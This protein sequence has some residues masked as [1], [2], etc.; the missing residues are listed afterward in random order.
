[1]G[2]SSSNPKLPVDFRNLGWYGQGNTTNTGGGQGSSSDAQGSNQTGGGG[3]Q[4]PFGIGS[5]GNSRDF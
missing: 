5:G 3:T 4:H 1:M 2:N